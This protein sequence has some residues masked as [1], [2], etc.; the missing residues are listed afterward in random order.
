MIPSRRDTARGS[1]VIDRKRELMNLGFGWL[2]LPF[3]VDWGSVPSYFAGL[4]LF[5]AAV[6]LSGNRKDRRAEQA[7]KV[8]AWVRVPE[9]DEDQEWRAK[10]CNSS[11]AG[12][13]GVTLV[14]EVER[15]AP[16]SRG[17]KDGGPEG[18]LMSK[19]KYAS[20][21]GPGESFD[22]AIEGRSIAWKRL[23]FTDAAGQWWIR[24]PKRLRRV[25]LFERLLLRAARLDHRELEKQ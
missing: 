3:L 8:S 5:V 14:V 20:D 16:S 13:T 11:D 2:H 18:P 19:F 4:S 17:R 24:T 12:V 10:V 6:T 15:K 21:L 1:L 25:G 22:Y 9:R 7:S 23:D